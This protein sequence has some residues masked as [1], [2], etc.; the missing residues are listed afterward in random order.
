[1]FGQRSKPPGPAVLFTL[2]VRMMF[3]RLLTLFKLCAIMLQKDMLTSSRFT[4]AVHILTMLA[5]MG[6]RTITSCYIA[7]SVNTNAVV[8]RRI[9]SLLATA[10]LV[11]SVEGAGGGTKIAKSVSLITLA[12]VYRA[13]EGEIDV[14]GDT[15]SEPNPNCPVGSVVQTALKERTARIELT[16]KQ[17]MSQITIA[18]LLADVQAAA[19][20]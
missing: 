16:I 4:V 8:I 10:G 11:T 18:D 6:E 13:V 2:A 12:D 1:M 3:P 7:A 5:Y 15:R 14:F 19:Q 17:E 9:V 20:E